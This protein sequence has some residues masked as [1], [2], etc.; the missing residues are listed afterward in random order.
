MATQPIDVNWQR[1]Q[2]SWCPAPAKP[3]KKRISN[4]PQLLH[5]A[6]LLPNFCRAGEL[7]TI[8]LFTIAG[9]A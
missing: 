9:W 2:I 6:E 7:I 1:P 3:V 8:G 5:A 4:Q